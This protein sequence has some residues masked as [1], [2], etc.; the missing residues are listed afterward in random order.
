MHSNSFGKGVIRVPQRGGKPDRFGARAGP[1]QRSVGTFA[2]PEEAATA[3]AEA[4]AKLAAGV[5]PWDEEQ[6]ANKHKR[7]EVRHS[8]LASRTM[9]PLHIAHVA[10]TSLAR[11]LCA[12]GAQAPPP[13]RKT[14]RRN[15]VINVPKN[16]KVPKD[17]EERNPQLPTSVPMPSH[18]EDITDAG[19]RAMWEQSV[20]MDGEAAPY[21]DPLD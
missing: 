9:R 10:A 5:S 4:E 18:V 6:R 20:A 21:V 13:E 16:G 15:G 19:M 8:G 3:A 1:S 7:G 2:T 14:A 17:K 11:V 12:F